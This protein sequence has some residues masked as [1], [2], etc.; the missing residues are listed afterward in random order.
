MTESGLEPSGVA[1]VDPK[2]EKLIYKLTPPQTTLK[3]CYYLG[4]SFCVAGVLWDL[5]FECFT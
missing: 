3:D 2:D 1:Y 5:V 4:T